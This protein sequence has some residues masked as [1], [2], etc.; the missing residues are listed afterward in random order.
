MP[1]RGECYIL[2]LSTTSDV[3]V[4][5]L[6]FYGTVFPLLVCH[7]SFFQMSNESKL[8]LSIKMIK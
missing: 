6:V 5:M 2:Q 3:A 4:A 1:K 8:L 7:V